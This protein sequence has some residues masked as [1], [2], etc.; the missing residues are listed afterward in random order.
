MTDKKKRGIRAIAVLIS[1]CLVGGSIYL[2]KVWNY[3]KTVKNLTFSEIAME[4]MENGIYTGECDVDFI[5]AKVAVTVENGT[6]TQIEILEHKN[7]RGAPAEKIIAEM[8]R[9]QSVD[10]D[11]VSG[12]TNSSQVIKKAVEN[13][14]V[15]SAR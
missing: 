5:H 12:A 4:E 15:K 10:V 9:K 14:L 8:V 11:A 1:L 2:V 3:Q 7:E 13:A 6:I